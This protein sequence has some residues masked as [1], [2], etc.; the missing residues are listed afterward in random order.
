MVRKRKNFKKIAIYSSLKNNK[1]PQIA[2]QLEEIIINMGLEVFF[3][4]SSKDILKTSSS[5]VSEKYINENADLVIAIGGDGTLLSCARKFGSH[6]LPVLGVNLG[7]LGFLTDIAPDEL[8]GSLQN[9]FKGEYDLE[10]RF[11]LNAKVNDNS[12][13]N[14]ALN[15]VVIH[16]REV[17]QLIEYELFI[18][19]AF[20]YRQKADGIIVN[21]PTGSTGYSL[22][23]NGPIM[24]PSVKA[25]TLLPMFPHSLDTRPLLVDESS[26]IVIKICRKGKA[27]LSLDS[28][29]Y[30]NL[31]FDNQIKITKAKPKLFLIH[32]YNHDFFSACRNKLGWSLGMPEQYKT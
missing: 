15:E 10:E 25:I 3:P 13:E 6:N 21:T 4:I 20:V 27:T 19:D 23:G 22:S 28:H 24:H 26:E 16:S 18:N 31:K 5:I 11:F 1:V 14:I 30:H 8:T 12:F 29:N 9:V 2:K 17:A 32:P 7:Q